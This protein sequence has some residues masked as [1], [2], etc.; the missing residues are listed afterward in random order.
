MCG[1][2][3]RSMMVI[4]TKVML[5][6][7]AGIY[8]MRASSVLFRDEAFDPLMIVAV[9]AFLL[10]VALFY[11]LPAGPGPWAYAVIALCIV[12]VAAN[13]FLLFAPDAAHGTAENMTF[14]AA[15]VIAWGFVGLHVSLSVIAGAPANNA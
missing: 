13:I 3:E 12:G 7:L 15:S 5:V 6:G 2:G 1:K 9:L 14:S 4:A 8:A 10:S 11:R